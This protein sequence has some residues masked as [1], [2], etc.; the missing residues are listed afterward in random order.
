MER[1]VRGFATGY[2]LLTAP[3][4]TVTGSRRLRMNHTDGELL[5]AINNGF[6]G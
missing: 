6:K 4:R 3:K 2:C 5:C 1:L